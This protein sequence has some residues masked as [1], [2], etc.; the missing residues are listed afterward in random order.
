MKEREGKLKELVFSKKI[1][2]GKKRKGREREVFSKK[3][4]EEKE[5]IR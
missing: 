3:F 2:E 1:K 4:K 5:M